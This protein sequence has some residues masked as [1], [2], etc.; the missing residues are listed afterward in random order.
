MFVFLYIFVIFCICI[1]VYEYTCIFVY[2]YT[3]SLV[4]E[5]AIHVHWCGWEYAPVCARGEEGTPSGG[6]GP[7]YRSILVLRQRGKGGGGGEWRIEGTK[8]P[9][10]N[11]HIFVRSDNGPVC[12]LPFSD[13]QTD[14]VVRNRKVFT[15]A[16]CQLKGWISSFSGSTVLSSV[17]F[18]K[19]ENTK[20]GRFTHICCSKNLT[21]SWQMQ[22]IK[23]IMWEYTMYIFWGAYTLSSNGFLESVL[24]RTAQG[25]FPC[26][27]ENPWT[28][29]LRT[30]SISL[31]E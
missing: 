16:L 7:V 18:E 24:K 15:H 23:V 1:F 20:Q 26:I 3:C 12:S 17:F 2:L 13:H 9:S 4:V 30:M 21:G 11:P 6:P 27:Q 19:D 25:Q 22:N 28:E 14:I 8:S 10:T 5:A 29:N 31:W